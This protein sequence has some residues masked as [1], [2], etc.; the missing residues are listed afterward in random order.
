MSLKAKGSSDGR[1]NS[2]YYGEMDRHL[3]VLS[4]EHIVVSPLT[5]QKTKTSKE[6]VICE[7]LLQGSI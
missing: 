7:H 1:Y 2:S 4:G 6:S 3:K 5:F